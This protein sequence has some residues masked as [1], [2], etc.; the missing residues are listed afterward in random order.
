MSVAQISAGHFPN[1]RLLET[2]V[3]GQLHCVSDCRQF[4]DCLS[5]NSEIFTLKRTTT[6][7]KEVLIL[8]E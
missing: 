7:K 8:V 5:L 6:V 3:I 2:D 4:G 1:V